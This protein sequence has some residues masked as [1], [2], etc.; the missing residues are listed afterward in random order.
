MKYYIY[1][2]QKYDYNDTVS[3]VRDCYNI[4]DVILLPARSYLLRVPFIQR[5]KGIA[6]VL[7]SSL[8]LKEKIPDEILDFDGMFGISNKDKDIFIIDCGHEYANE[9][10][11]KKNMIINPLRNADVDSIR[12]KID[13]RLSEYIYNRN[14]EDPIFLGQIKNESSVDK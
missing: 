12:W 6:I 8:L 4:E 13:T 9:N 14:L 2:N 1:E 3:S 7:S 11:N 10:L 5:Y